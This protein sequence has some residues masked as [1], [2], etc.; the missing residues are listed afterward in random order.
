MHH[1]KEEEEEMFP[2]ARKAEVDMEALGEQMK[3]RKEEL[4][5]T[6]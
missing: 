1:V 6:A 5:E 2:S 3:A 4:M